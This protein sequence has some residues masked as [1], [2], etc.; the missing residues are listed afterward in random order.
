M[1]KAITRVA[2]RKVTTLCQLG[3]AKSIVTPIAKL[4]QRANQ[5]TAFRFSRLKARG[6]TPH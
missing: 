6:N 5:G 2:V 4:L 3:P 1:A